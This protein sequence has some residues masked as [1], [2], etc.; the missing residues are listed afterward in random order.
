[1]VRDVE[2][3]VQES[4]VRLW[5][6]RAANPIESAKAFLFQVARRLALDILR[7]D[8]AS[9]IKGITDLAARYVLDGKPSAAEIACSRE[10]VE[11]LAQALHALPPRC[12]EIV[13]LR[14]FKCVPQK[15]IARQLGIS[16]QTVQGQVFRGVKRM[17]EFLRHRGVRCH[18]DHET[19]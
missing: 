6:A 1:M 12:R 7:R 3:V 10:E 19:G 4:Y 15:E 5:K 11:L 14:K 18:I 2:D 13:V 8:R 17:T 16:E 9:P